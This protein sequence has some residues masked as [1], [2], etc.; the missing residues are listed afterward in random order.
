MIKKVGTLCLVCCFL[1]AAL[2]AAASAEVSLSQQRLVANN[3]A[4]LQNQ[5][6]A[7][8]SDD[9]MSLN[10]LTVE[11]LEELIQSVLKKDTDLEPVVAQYVADMEEQ[12]EAAALEPA[13]V[14]PLVYNIYTNA[15]GMMQIVEG[16]G[17]PVCMAL[18]LSKN[19]TSIISAQNVYAV[20]AGKKT[21]EDI[22]PAQNAMKYYNFLASVLDV[23][24]CNPSAGVQTY[25]GI[26]YTFLMLFLF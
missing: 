10:G 14:T 20:C 17:E 26:L 9:S 12:V 1:V 25:V 18:R 23:I 22:A 21:S 19:A 11:F 4:G 7:D 8:A 24:I 5:L 3:I 16:G 2:P 6:L 13:C 15:L